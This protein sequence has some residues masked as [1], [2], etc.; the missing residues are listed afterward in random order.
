M[1]NKWFKS[2]ALYSGVVFLLGALSSL[3]AIAVTL[4]PGSIK[5]VVKANTAASGT[6]SIP[7]GNSRLTLINRDLP[8]QVF[9]TTTDDVG[10]FAFSDLP[11][12]RYVLTAEADGLPTVT[13]EIVLS[14]G[15]NLIVEIELTASVLESVTVRDEEGLLSSGETTTSNTVREQTLKDLPLRAEN[16]Q[17]ALPMT[18][19]VVR[20]ARGE[21]HLKGTRVGQSAY[22]VNGVDVTDPATGKLAFDIPLEAAATVQIEENPY[23]AEFGR[24]TG[25]ATNL[26]T[27][28]GGKH[29]KIRAARVFPTFRY[30]LTGPIDSFR[31]RVTFSGPLV[32][33]RLFF[34]Q[35]LEY[36]FTRVRVPSLPSAQNDFTST[37][38]NS[39]S[40]IDFNINKN[41]RAKFVAAIFPQEDRH[42]G[43]NTFNPVETTP[44]IKQRGSLFSI[45][46]QSIF[47]D[48]SFLSS[49]LSYKTFDVDVLPQGTEP[50]TLLP[51]GNTGNYFAESHRRTRRFQ[52]QETYYARP[53]TMAGQHSLSVGG[54]FA[55]T[56]ISGRFKNN[57]LFIRRNNG[58]LAQRVDF[59]GPGS[60]AFQVREFSAFAQDRWTIS[61]KFVIDGG[62]RLDRDG[63]ARNAN[64]APRASFLLVPLKNSH[65]IIR[66]GI[67]LFYDRMPLSVGY[68][69]FVHSR[70]DLE[71]G[72]QV[73]DQLPSAASFKDYPQRVVTT[74]ALDGVSVTDGPRLFRNDT[75]APLR[76]VRS[77]RWS[78]QFEQGLTKDLTVRVGF[79]DRTTKNELIIEPST[80][81][82]N[83]GVLNLSS[84]GRSHYR[85]L[86]FLVMYNDPRWGNW[87]ASYV[88]SSAQGDLN[89]A[90][91]YLWGLPAF[92]IRPNEF[93]PLPFDVPHRFLLN[94]ELKLP[95]DI[96]FAPSVEIR[97]GF[98]YSIVNEQLDFVGPRNR[99]G[100]FPSFMSLDVQ[101]TKGFHIPKFEKHKIRIGAAIFNITNHF[102]PRDLQ[103]NLGSSSF[104]QFYN[105]LGPSV[106]GKFEVAF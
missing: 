34:V 66:G 82:G 64:V 62:F 23:S 8:A 65:T 93:G 24:L 83:S 80:K 37:A 61:R 10:A 35:S 106:R 47:G 102:N 38:F 18:P 51:D 101:V 68:F 90:D 31:P 95:F 6:R 4:L 15:A 84:M 70:P 69:D 74:F 42:V 3:S 11:A 103:N 50:M 96:A 28:S 12:A 72:D 1:K 91:N 9:K 36:R 43:L 63:I 44:N 7:L 45:S 29:F 26:E 21:D 33:D 78:L 40:Q 13:R 85:E 14:E 39:F 27:K 41:E 16:Y 92:V 54:E 22:T 88:W 32:R 56:S 105:S 2:F 59:A 25:G 79:M 46:E 55:R 76:N 77:V 60:S 71:E 94:G 53:L 104:S 89:T 100:R 99:A 48:A 98:P 58:T 30:M 49:A 87:N 73:L 20:D 81:T 86:Q 75:E 17:A 19:G 57:S 5:G 67:G 97:S 52:W